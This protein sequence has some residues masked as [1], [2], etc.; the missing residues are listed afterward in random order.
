MSDINVMLLLTKGNCVKVFKLISKATRM[1]CYFS[2]M[3][4]EKPFGL[5]GMKS[6]GTEK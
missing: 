3:P 5:E 1:V 2:W 4:R 6:R